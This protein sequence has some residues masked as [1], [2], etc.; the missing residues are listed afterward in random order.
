MNYLPGIGDQ[1]MPGFA[2]KPG[3]TVTVL[4]SA[5]ITAS[6][7][8]SS[9]EIWLPNGAAGLRLIVDVS[10]IGGT[11][12]TITGISINQKVGSTTNPNTGITTVNYKTIYT[13]GGLAINAVSQKTFLLA[14]AAVQSQDDGYIQGAPPS[15]FQV[16]VT[17]LDNNSITYSLRVNALRG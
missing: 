11:P 13:F 7:P 3:D 10:A 15:E 6:G 16:G 12:G 2:I 4:P 1:A 14:P 17:T 8:Q 9:Q 5:T